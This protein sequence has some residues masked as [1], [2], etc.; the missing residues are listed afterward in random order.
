MIPKTQH[1]DALSGDKPV[2]LFISG[3][4]VWKSV[5]AAVKFNREFC[6][7]AEKIEEV[8]A[9]WILAEFE[10]GEA[11]VAQQTPQSFFSIRGFFP[12]VAREAAGLGGARAM[13]AV[14]RLLPSFSPTGGEGVRRT[15]EGEFGSLLL[16]T[17]VPP[18]P[19]PLPRWGRGRLQRPAFV[20]CG[21]QMRPALL[22]LAEDQR[23]WIL[24]FIAHGSEK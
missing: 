10:L 14:L 6:D 19:S 22:S 5:S 11:V 12:Q 1:L 9:A 20:I 18:H 8:N 2:S 3:A 15:D 7:R 4:L 21:L 17:S 23:G 24:I 16:V 13:F